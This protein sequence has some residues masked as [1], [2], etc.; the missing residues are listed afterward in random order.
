MYEVR[1]NEIEA[2]ILLSFYKY[3]NHHFKSNACY[4]FKIKYESFSSRK[5]VEMNVCQRAVTVSRK[6]CSIL[7]RMRALWASWLQNEGGW[8]RGTSGSRRAPPSEAEAPPWT[9]CR[10]RPRWA[11]ASGTAAA[12]GSSC[13]WRAEVPEEAPWP[14]PQRPPQSRRRAACSPSACCVGDPGTAK[15]WGA[16]GMLTSGAA[17]VVIWGAG[18][19]PWSGA[20]ALVP[21]RHCTRAWSASGCWCWSDATGGRRRSPWTRRPGWAGA[22][23]PRGR[24]T[25]QGRRLSRSWWWGSL[26]GRTPF[27]P[28]S[29]RLVRRPRYRTPPRCRPECR[30]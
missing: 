12:A 7:T 18:A 11:A 9:T 20:G 28:V 3:F 25:P 23:S 30:H 19:P 22:R 14:R 27:S 24:W 6:L 5:W 21:G 2:L 17:G 10:K 13:C 4:L 29:P 26:P 15:T 16:S 8:P 1:K